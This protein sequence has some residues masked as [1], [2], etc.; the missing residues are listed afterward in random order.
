MTHSFH[1]TTGRI[2]TAAHVVVVTGAGASAESGIPTF[3][4]ALTGHWAKYDPMQLATPEAFA[5]NPALV[6][7]WYD[8]RRRDALGCRPNPGHDALARLEHALGARGA[9][10]TLLTQNVDRLHQR[11]GS[12]R[13][14]ELHGSLYRWRCTGCGDDRLEENP[15]PLGPYP[16]RCSVC[17]GSRRPGVVWFGEELPEPATAAAGNALVSCDVFLS[18]G[19]SSVVYP[20]AGYAQTAVAAGAWCV[21]VNPEPT[22]LSGLFHQHL[23][24]KAGEVLPGLVDAAISRD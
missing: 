11:A 20:V 16:P 15:E 22:E 3:R 6:S 7:R 19:T 2:R 9:R 18:V 24:G 12:R 10:F 14:H 8:R 4:D 17:D 5:A 13:V 21:E 23:R 1:E